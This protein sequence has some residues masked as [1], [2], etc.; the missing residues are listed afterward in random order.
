[1]KRLFYK[2]ILFLLLLSTLPVI[3]NADSEVTI[4]VFDDHDKYVLASGPYGIS[5]RLITLA[6]KS[7]NITLVPQE[8]SW[9]GSVKRLK[10]KKVDLIFA[11]FKTEE[12]AKWG[13][14]SKPLMS[15]TSSIFTLP[16]NP[17]NHVSEID[18]NVATIGV[19]ANSSQE[20]IAKELGFKNIYATVTRKQ[21]F[22]MLRQRRL[23]YLFFAV[24]AVNYYCMFYEDPTDRDCLKRVGGNYGGKFIH[25]L[26]LK[27]KKS[28][29]IMKKLNNGLVAIKDSQEVISYF[30]EFNYTDQDIENWKKSLSEDVN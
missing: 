29:A 30:K 22:Y 23:D 27:T 24:G 3:A 8:S 14:F 11:A 9:Q 6:A 10:G 15:T 2:A 28:K 5:W 16:E 13:Y 20:T 4:A 26:S 25:T 18:L 1:M 17:I 19:S 12:R 21:L 7:Q